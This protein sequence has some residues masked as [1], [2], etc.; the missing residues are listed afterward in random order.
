M[1]LEGLF[2]LIYVSWGAVAVW[3][4][5]QLNGFL[6]E[7]PRIDDASCLQRFKSVVRIQ[8]FLALA[9]IA[10]LASGMIVGLAL[11]AS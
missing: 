5:S 11:I 4:L 9:A 2:G 3:S 8:M 6:A 10:V 1:I 7:T